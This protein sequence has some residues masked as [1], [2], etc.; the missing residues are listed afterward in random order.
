VL[1]A[2]QQ[3]EKEQ[4]ESKGGAAEEHTPTRINRGRALT[5]ELTSIQESEA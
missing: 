2:E 1:K 3:K 4:A 5:V